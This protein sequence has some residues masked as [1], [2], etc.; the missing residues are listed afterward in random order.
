MDIRATV[1]RRNRS[2]EGKGFSLGE[3]KEA[4]TDYRHALRIGL[5]VDLRRKTGHKENIKL[6]K[7]YLKNIEKHA[8]PE[9]KAIE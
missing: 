5:P 4:G 2:R 7:R 9:E 1:R 8:V 3:L 6:L